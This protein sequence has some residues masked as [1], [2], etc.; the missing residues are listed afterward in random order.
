MRDVT[1]CV[2]KASC[3]LSLYQG[4]FLRL[5]RSQQLPDQSSPLLHC[6]KHFETLSH[7][8]KH[9][10]NHTEVLYICSC[11]PDGR[12]RS[13]NR[14]HGEMLFVERKSVLECFGAQWH[15]LAMVTLRDNGV[16]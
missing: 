5:L 6:P 10:A 14:K 7:Q 13:Y 8:H 9:S 4:I 3:R 1:K 11:T 12:V 15:L 16:A 2:V